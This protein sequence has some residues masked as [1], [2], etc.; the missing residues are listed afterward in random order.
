MRELKCEVPVIVVTG[1]GS[2]EVCRIT[3]KLGVQDYIRKPFKVE[4]LRVTIKAILDPPGGTNSPVDRAVTFM[5]ENYDKSISA[6]DV[7]R[8][9]GFSYVHW[10]HLFKIALMAHFER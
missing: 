9:I 3:F 8:E 6:V 5:E 7:A 4:E 10:A 1:K 2:E